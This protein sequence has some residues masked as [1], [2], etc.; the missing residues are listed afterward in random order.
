MT[1]LSKSE[2]TKETTM[3][4][5]RSF[6]ILGR[7]NPFGFIWFDEIKRRDT[8]TVGEVVYLAGRAQ[9]V[10]ANPYERQGMQFVD[11]TAQFMDAG[12]A[13]ADID[14]TYEAMREATR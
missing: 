8:F 5:N 9:L 1:P 10:K 3:T 6:L 7:T 11:V 12:G 13:Q 4:D 2:T 14:E